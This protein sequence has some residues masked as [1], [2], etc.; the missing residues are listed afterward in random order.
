MAK[1]QAGTPAGLDD[2]PTWPGARSP[3]AG[4][5]YRKDVT[6]AGTGIEANQAA[7]L[8]P[9]DLLLI[10]RDACWLVD[11]DTETVTRL[12]VVRRSHEFTFW[13][14]IPDIDG[15]IYCAASGS[16]TEPS[17]DQPVQHVRFGNWGEVFRVRVRD[18]TIE[19]VAELVD[20]IDIQFVD[21]SQAI[22]SDFNNW[23]GTGQVY[24][25]N[26][27]V[28]NVTK[29]VDG[30]LVSE[31]YGACRD[32]DGVLWVAN[33]YGLEYD[34][35]I[36]KVD[37]DGQQTVV[38]RKQGLYSGVISSIFPSYSQGKLL[39]VMVD[40]PYMKKSALLEFDKR[41]HALRPV[42]SASVERPAVFAPGCARQGNTV[43]IAEA[44]H[45]ELLQFYLKTEEII[46]TIDISAIRGRVKG[47]MHA[48][49]FIEAVSIVP[50]GW[51][52]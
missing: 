6:S 42:L 52:G 40:W 10:Y 26:R 20:P 8:K 17:S 18:R 45:N 7:R 33:A 31:P 35:A 36:I 30:G 32:N 47:I 50:D 12:F 27:H 21:D 14:A 25:M 5:R 13:R 3:S 39:C 43:W 15:Y 49:D 24:L 23:G 29:L 48:W 37:V 44:Y 38:R 41:T 9:G 28:G 2:V 11:P 16:T 22:V 1:L 4:S 46:R 34:S 19:T 51:P